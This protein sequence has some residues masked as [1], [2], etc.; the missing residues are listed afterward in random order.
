MV[1]KKEM[2]EM[3]K[4]GI[5]LSINVVSLIKFQLGDVENFS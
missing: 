4:Y 5:V 3:E 2:Q 1:G